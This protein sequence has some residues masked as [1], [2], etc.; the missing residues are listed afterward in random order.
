MRDCDTEERGLAVGAKS[1]KRYEDLGCIVHVKG[2][3]F[4]RERDAFSIVMGK[5][6]EGDFRCPWFYSLGSSSMRK[7]CHLSD[8]NCE[9]IS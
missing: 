8:I 6:G 1:L 5:E 9:I 7:F 2:L 3:G 4:H